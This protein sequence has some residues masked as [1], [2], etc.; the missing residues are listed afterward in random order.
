MVVIFFTRPR[1]VDWLSKLEDRKDETISV[2]FTAL[3]EIYV[4]NLPKCC[5]QLTEILEMI[6]YFVYL[7]RRYYCLLNNVNL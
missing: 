4:A 1:D 7:F 3:Y 2:F 5:L 6:H